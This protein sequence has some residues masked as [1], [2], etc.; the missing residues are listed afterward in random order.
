[1]NIIWKILTTFCITGIITS[2]GEVEF[3]EG[4]EA[5]EYYAGKY[6]VEDI[7][8]PQINVN[9]F[10]CG[11]SETTNVQ[12]L[13]QLKIDTFEKM[14]DFNSKLLSIEIFEL[15]DR[16]NGVFHM[17][18]I[19]TEYN[20]KVWNPHKNYISEIDNN[21]DS[22]LTICPGWRLDEMEAPKHSNKMYFGFLI[23]GQ[24]YIY[25]KG[26]NGSIGPENSKDNLKS[27]QPKYSNGFQFWR[28]SSADGGHGNFT[29]VFDVERGAFVWIRYNG[30]A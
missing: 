3:L 26:R 16:L 11:K 1:M 27:I 13:N 15:N 18:N 22:Y 7:S 8:L 29:A 6:K 23:D 28:W 19:P 2:C 12:T 21:F 25:I 5:K 17:V 20:D 9:S 24:R 10:E 30:Y 14:D 4:L